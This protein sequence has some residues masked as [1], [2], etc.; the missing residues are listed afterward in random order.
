MLRVP[1]QLAHVHQVHKSRVTA[2]LV[3]LQKNN[4]LYE[5][6]KIDRA[7]MENWRYA[8]STHVPSIIMDRMR[9]EEPSVCEKTQT[10]HIVS[11]S[12]RGLEENGFKSINELLTS[13]VSVS[14]HGLAPAD[15]DVES[16]RETTSPGMFP[17]DGPAEEGRGRDA[18]DKDYK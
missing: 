10:D 9:R 8:D 5:H 1:H 17:L 18:R 6:I 3:W 12:N 2:A 13:M 15:S 16:I 11:D 4:P 7:E 14:V